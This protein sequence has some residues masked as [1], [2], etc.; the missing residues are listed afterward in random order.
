MDNYGDPM[1][2]EPPSQFVEML[3]RRGRVREDE[4]LALLG[5]GVHNVRK[6]PVLQR[7]AATHNAMEAR[8]PLIY[9][10]RIAVDGLLGE[11]DLLRLTADSKYVPIDIKSGAGEETVSD[12]RTRPKKQYAVQLALYVD[13]LERLQLSNGRR[14]GFI[15]DVNGDEV[16]YDLMASKGK[17]VSESLWDDYQECVVIAREIASGVRNPGPSYQ[18]ECRNCAWRTACLKDLEQ[19]N[20]LTL[21]AGLGRSKRDAL[22]PFVSTIDEFAATTPQR[23]V[24]AKGNSIVRGVGADLLKKLHARAVLKVS[25]GT[26]YLTAPVTIPTNRTELFFDL[27]TDPMS[28]HCYLHGFVERR[29]RHSASER[30]FGFFS[31][32]PTAQS[33]R[34]A[35]KAAWDFVRSRMPCT[36]YV[37]SKYERTWWRALQAKY[38]D[39][40]TSA[41]IEALFSDGTAID[42][43]SIVQS[44]T[45]WPTRDLSI[46]TL[47][48]Y[49][50]FSWR[51]ADPSGA[52]SIEWY[53]RYL[54]GDVAAKQRILEYNEDDCRAT[55]VLLDAIPVLP[56]GPA[57][58]TDGIL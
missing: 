42:L 2:R 14:E 30:Y 56:L 52:A 3:W 50:G 15:W 48:K 9:G 7:E 13:I 20:D 49:L 24:D 1:V 12:D 47:A 29:S 57:S 35:F 45:E 34:E 23:F 11:P 33:E 26:P 21:L 17:R 32:H 18:A 51:D 58:P 4:V 55:R 28:E 6:V 38:G 41:E 19:K 31:E 10:A 46:K 16:L 54:R 5:P 36:I 8:V 39:V 53:D 25:G 27:E 40:C 22:L 44:S 37:Y 43:L